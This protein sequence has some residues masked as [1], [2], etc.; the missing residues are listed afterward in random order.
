MGWLGRRLLS[1]YNNSASS[2]F[3][4]AVQR[5][6]SAGNGV[7]RVADV[8]RVQR[9]PLLCLKVGQP[10]QGSQSGHKAIF[11][12]P[13]DD[14]P[15]NALKAFANRPPWDSKAAALVVRPGDGF[16]IVASP[17]EDAIVYPLR[18]DELELTTKVR[19]DKRK[20]QSPIGAVVLQDSFWQ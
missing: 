5:H 13:R 12:A 11:T 20:H 2:V 7:A 9:G 17:K 16:L 6:T 15:R 8:M 1:N 3:I 19:S 14:K 18:L 4:G 10:A